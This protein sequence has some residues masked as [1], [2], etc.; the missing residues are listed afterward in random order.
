MRIVKVTT[1]KI[2]FLNSFENKHQYS[3]I[4]NDT[5]EKCISCKNSISASNSIIPNV[6][7]VKCQKASREFG[8]DIF[9]YHNGSCKLYAI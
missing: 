5:R 2:E 7:I 8:S 3:R 4:Y 1:A 6:K 9:S